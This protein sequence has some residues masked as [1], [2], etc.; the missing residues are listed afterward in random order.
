MNGMIAVR[1]MRLLINSIFNK[2]ISNQT[3][4]IPR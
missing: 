1:V 4:K 3:L 2:N